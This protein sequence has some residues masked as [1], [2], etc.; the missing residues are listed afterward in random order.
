MR[1]FVPTPCNEQNL[2]PV[3]LHIVS[4]FGAQMKFLTI[5]AAS[6]GLIL[7][8]GFVFSA[9]VPYQKV[10]FDAARAA[11]KPVAVVFH[12]DWCPTCR[13]QAPLLKDLSQQPDLSQVTLYVASYDEE[14]ALEKSLGVTKQ[15]TL[16]VFKQGR[17]AGRSTGDTNEASLAMLLRRAIP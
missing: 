3:Y 1:A 5:A 17:E 14:K 4:T 8:S 11:G 15:S 6:L 13:A 12:A 16:V 10:E 9:E 7:F 2:N